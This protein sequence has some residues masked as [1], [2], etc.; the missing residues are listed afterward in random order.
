MKEKNPSTITVMGGPNFNGVD[1]DWIHNFF[2]E[3][4]NLDAYIYGEG[5]WSFTR[6]VELLARQ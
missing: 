2:Q 3:R 1:L 4:P 6:F 5:E